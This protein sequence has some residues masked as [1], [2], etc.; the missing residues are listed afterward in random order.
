MVKRVAQQAPSGRFSPTVGLSITS[1]C[2]QGTPPAA[3]PQALGVSQAQQQVLRQPPQQHQ[4]QQHRHHPPFHPPTGCLGPQQ[5]DML[6]LGRE[7]LRVLV[8]QVAEHLCLLL[9]PLLQP[10]LLLW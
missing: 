2:R 3:T 9:R 5:T 4:H 10:I 7:L 8:L 1:R 6:L